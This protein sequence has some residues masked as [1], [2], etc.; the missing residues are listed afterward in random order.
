MEQVFFE[1]NKTELDGLI[2]QLEEAHSVR[3]KTN[4][5]AFALVPARCLHLVLWLDYLTLTYLGYLA[6]SSG[7]LAHSHVVVS[8]AVC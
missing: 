2:G 3:E 4:Q 7:Y 8:C 5:P 6:R 1:L